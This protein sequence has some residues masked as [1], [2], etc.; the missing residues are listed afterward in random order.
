MLIT[1]LSTI[2]FCAVLWYGSQPSIASDDPNLK[3]LGRLWAVVLLLS[4]ATTL[5]AWIEVANA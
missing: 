3:K 4:F 5:T 1:I 2:T